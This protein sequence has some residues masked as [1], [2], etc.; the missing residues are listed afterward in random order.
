LD[1]PG[2]GNGSTWNTRVV[3]Q[4]RTRGTGIDFD[5]LELRYDNGG[6]QTLLW[7]DRTYDEQ[8]SATPLGGFGGTE[9]DSLVVFDI[10]GFNP[11]E[12]T[13][14]F[15]ADGSSMSL[16]NV[17]VDVFTTQ[18]SLAPV[19]EPSSFALVTIGLLGLSAFRRRR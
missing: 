8:L 10:L 4:F 17:A 12:F 9:I 18:A 5:G 2:Y 7:S 19:P 11:A 14:A 3:L 13:L 15:A 6:T 16:A 1:V